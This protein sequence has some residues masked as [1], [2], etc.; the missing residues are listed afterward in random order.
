MPDQNASPVGAQIRAARAIL[1]LS[2]K[3][4]AAA[5]GIGWATLQRLETDTGMTSTRPE[6]IKKVIQALESQGIEFIG[7]P[8]TSPGVR[9]HRGDDTAA[10]INK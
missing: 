3:Q 5:A 10:S 8:L 2:A 7:D 1:G 9:L 4:L 6:T